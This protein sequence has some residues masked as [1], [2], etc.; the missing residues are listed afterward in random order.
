MPRKRTIVDSEGEPASKSSKVKRNG[1]PEG[2]RQP[3]P[4]FNP[5][6]I[7]KVNRLIEPGPVLLMTTGSLAEKTHNIM[8]IGFHMMLQ[9][10]SPT[11]IA[12]SIGPCHHS[13]T[14][15]KKNREC[16]L[17]IPSSEIAGTIVDIGN[18]SGVD[19]N[20]WDSF[21]LTAMPA[22][23]VRAPLIGNG[24]IL[25]NVECVVEDT[26]LVGRYDLWVLRVVAAWMNPECAEHGMKTF[27]YCGDGTFT[28]DGEMLDLR[29]RMVKWKEFQD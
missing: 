15:L 7:S 21:G 14:A 28:V 4:Q 23:K 24:E 13:Y 3:T 9:H 27:H 8:T 20:K 12:A 18:C 10:E 19:V 11:L 26:K 1:W 25:A 16:T 29:N 5:Y 17:A 22:K 2:K 6:P